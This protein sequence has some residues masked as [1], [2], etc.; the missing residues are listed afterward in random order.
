[1]ATWLCF[2]TSLGI[3]ADQLV[4]LM[5]SCMETAARCAWGAPVMLL[6]GGGTN[7]FRFYI[8]HWRVGT[9]L[10]V[11]PEHIGSSIKIISQYV[12]PVTFRVVHEMKDLSDKSELYFLK[13][14]LK[15][16]IKIHTVVFNFHFPTVAL[17]ISKASSCLLNNQQQQADIV[18]NKWHFSSF[19][20]PVGAPKVVF[21]PKEQVS[22][23]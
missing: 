16:N 6:Q 19:R 11:G 12:I 4:E 14:K 18:Q 13:I 7:L 3:V 5:V 1:M 20:C 2:T 21:P 23:K 9:N 10:I 17:P 15:E 22:L 8:N